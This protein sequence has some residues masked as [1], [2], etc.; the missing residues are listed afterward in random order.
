MLTDDYLVGLFERQRSC[1]AELVSKL[2]GL[3][4]DGWIE[5]LECRRLRFVSLMMKGYNL[6]DW[7]KK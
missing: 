6:F 2:E 1:S 7:K 4:K 5:L 3:E